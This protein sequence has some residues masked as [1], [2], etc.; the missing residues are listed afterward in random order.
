M[1]KLKERHEVKSKTLSGEA[2]S[3]NVH[4]VKDWLED[5]PRIIKDF[6]PEDVYNTDETGLQYKA[7]TQ[8]SLVL[9]GD[10]GHHGKVYKERVSLLLCVSWA[11]EKLKPLLI[12]KSPNPRALKGADMK[13]IPVHY[14]AQPK[15]WMTGAIFEEWLRGF[16]K[17][18]GKKN[19]HRK[20]LL[21][22][23]NASVYV[24]SLHEM[25]NDL[26]HTTV[27]LFPKNTTSHTQPLDA[28]IIQAVKLGYRSNLHSHIVSKLD[29]DMTCDPYKDITVALVIVW[30]TRS[31]MKLNARTISRCFLKCGFRMNEP[32]SNVADVVVVEGPEA[33]LQKQESSDNNIFPPPLTANV[34]MDQ[35][36]LA[37]LEPEKNLFKRHAG[38]Q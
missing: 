37:V 27:V 19:K 20:V 15:A 17:E 12:G 11:G 16:D 30:L 10:T 35:A 25:A 7:T 23:D 26:S 8:R 32:P 34:L 14:K 5:L 2:A 24:S 21:F 6:K 36:E 31:W 38:A 29:A 3:V 33:D 4:V 9:P 18:V 13:R 1:T 22:M 28:G